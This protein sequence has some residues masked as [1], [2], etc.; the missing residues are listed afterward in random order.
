MYID[1]LFKYR[2]IG[3]SLIGSNMFFWIDLVR[4]VSYS[5]YIIN[6]FNVNYVHFFSLTNNNKFK[7]IIRC[8]IYK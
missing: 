1:N 8:I 7:Y 3:T 5:L 4:F 2:F 6:M